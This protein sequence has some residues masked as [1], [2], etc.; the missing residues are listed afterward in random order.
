LTKENT[1]VEEKLLILVIIEENFY[2]DSSII[3][4]FLDN[5]NYFVANFLESDL[6]AKDRV[7]LLLKLFKILNLIAMDKT[8]FLAELQITLK[9]FF[10]KFID[11]AQISYKIIS[12]GLRVLTY[13]NSLYNKFDY[14]CIDLL[15]V[16]TMHFDCSKVMKN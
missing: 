12:Y 15:S 9:D 2:K 5:F 11:K 13:S 16:I 10:Y 4:A 1:L 7:I 8:D 14:S 6:C 3:K